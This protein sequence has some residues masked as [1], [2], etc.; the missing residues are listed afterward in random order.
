MLL[1]KT[2]VSRSKSTPKTWQ[3]Q[4]P[5]SRSHR[6]CSSCC[7]SPLHHPPQPLNVANPPAPRRRGAASLQSCPT[8]RC[9]FFV[10]LHVFVCP[11]YSCN[12]KNTT[13]QNNQT[14]TKTNQKQGNRK[15]DESALVGR[16]RT[17]AEMAALVRAFP[18]VRAA[19]VGHSWAPELSCPAAAARSSSASASGVYGGGGLVPFSNASS[20][21][22][23]AIGMLTTEFQDLLEACGV[24]FFF[25]FC[26][27]F[28]LCSAPAY[29][30]HFHSCNPPHKP[31]KTKKSNAEKQRRAQRLLQGH[32]GRRG[33][34]DGH[35]AGRCDAARAARVSGQAPVRVGFVWG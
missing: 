25:V 13:Q 10:G 11:W 9:L 24:V 29:T 14:N 33:R 23:A 35:D 1:E 7:C 8:F 2:I 31:H 18:H 30:P 20:P 5:R 12:P 15:C 26:L 34:D 32:V 6:C 22:A 3:R 16:P 21:S 19:G 17:V 28:L 4:N 27:I